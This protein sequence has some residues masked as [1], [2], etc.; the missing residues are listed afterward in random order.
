MATIPYI[1][2]RIKYVPNSIKSAVPY[3][4]ERINNVAKFIKIEVLI[5]IFNSVSNGI[6]SQ[7]SRIYS[8][9]IFIIGE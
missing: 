5:T 7:K 1:T 9:I 2:D 3:V 6:L 8:V 4:T